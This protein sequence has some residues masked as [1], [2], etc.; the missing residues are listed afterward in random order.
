MDVSRRRALLALGGY[1]ALALLWTARLWVDPAHRSPPNRP[2][3]ALFTW[4]LTWDA[5]P[6]LSLHANQLNVPDGV[7]VMWQTGLLLPGLLLAPLT[8]AAGAQ[9]SYNLLLTLGPAL[10]AWSAYVVLR[11]L[12][13]GQAGPLLGGLLYGFGPAMVAQAYGGHLHL[14]LAFLPP[15]LLALTG[16]ALLAERDPLRTGVVVGLLTAAQLL[17]GAELLVITVLAGLL[18][19]LVLRSPWRRVGRFVAGA[20][21]A[22]LLVAGWPIAV[23]FLG[24]QHA[25][26]NVQVTGHYQEDVAAYVVPTRLMQLH[27]FAA[28]TDRFPTGIQERTA[29]LGALLIALVAV[30][31][32]R[33]WGDRRVR[34]GVGAGLVLGLL[35]LGADLRVAGYRTG[36]P[37]PWVL[38]ERAPVIGNVLPS[39]LPL[40]VALAVGLLLALAVERWGRRGAAL[41]VLAL[42]PLVPAP[43]AVVPTPPVPAYFRAEPTGTLLVLPFPTP[44]STDAMR[45]QAA[46]GLSFSMPGGFF[47]GPGRTG[48]AR[49]G[50][51]ATTS[52]LLLARADQGVALPVGPAEQAAFIRDLARWRAGA[53]V[54]G[55]ATHR[56][57]LRATVTALLGRPPEH[58]D[59]VDV[60]PLASNP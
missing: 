24:A 54:L 16:Q 40:L 44:T 19:A 35:S 30:F 27:P 31:A 39:R 33:Q 15:V 36:V 8:R 50:A 6:S 47:V 14:T 51:V 48:R 55:P 41:A 2:D 22:G 26:G 53:V 59:G 57:L 37:L 56:G 4:F 10:S 21:P 34:V 23:Q 3:V 17:I 45:W 5:H 13:R 32:S 1:L 49:F 25:A 18:I 12:V 28:L 38:V 11:R 20:A 43:L 7:N 9:V 46:A 29:Y 60:W 42:V 52:S 58:R